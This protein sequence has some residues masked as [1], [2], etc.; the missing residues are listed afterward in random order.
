MLGRDEVAVHDPGDAVRAEA[1]T[2]V[3]SDLCD[4]H[5]TVE[6]AFGVVRERYHYS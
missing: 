5:R 2:D 6:G 4:R 3:V 1:G